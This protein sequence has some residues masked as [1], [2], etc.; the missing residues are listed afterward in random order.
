MAAPFCAA[1]KE[2]CTSATVRSRL[3]ATD[4]SS[5]IPE[6]ATVIAGWSPKPPA[7]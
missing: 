4:P 6:F 5:R 7:R 2:A 1:Y 3:T